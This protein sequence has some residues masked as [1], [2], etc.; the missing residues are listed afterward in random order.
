VIELVR[1]RWKETKVEKVLN[2]EGG[3]VGRHL[4]L[5]GQQIINLAKSQAGKRTG[6]LRASIHIT[7]RGRNLPGQYIQVGSYLPY[8]LMHHQGTRP[9]VII[10]Q[11]RRVLR[12]FVKGV[13]IFRPVVLHP[14]T[15]PNRYL[16][17]SLRKVIN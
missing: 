17:D 14:G 8:A 13:M 10:P 11:K 5:K 3:L 7:K 9:R 15:R 12:F 16:T 6:A 4:R 1:I 2:S